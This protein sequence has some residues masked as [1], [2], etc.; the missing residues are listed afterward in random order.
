MGTLVSEYI[1]VSMS[2]IGCFDRIASPDPNAPLHELVHVRKKEFP[3]RIPLRAHVAHVAPILR[4]HPYFLQGNHIVLTFG[5]AI[6]DRSQALC[7]HFRKETESPWRERVAYQQLNVRICI[8][9]IDVRETIGLIGQLSLLRHVERPPVARSSQTASA[10]AAK[11][12]RRLCASAIYSCNCCIMVH[13]GR[14]RRRWVF[15]L[16]LLTQCTTIGSPYIF[17]LLRMP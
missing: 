6:C 1:W 5:E 4:F 9:R 10:L 3:V 12:V 15:I 8:L 13:R 17:L 7:A 2:T 11:L 16:L 14:L